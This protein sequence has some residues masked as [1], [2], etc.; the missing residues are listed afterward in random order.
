MV[1]R[2]LLSRAAVLLASVSSVLAALPPIQVR[3]SNFVD[4]STGQ[5]FAVLGVDYQPGGQGAYG[6]GKGDP[7]SDP[8]ACLRDAVVM[9]RLGV[10]TIRIYNIDSSL[11][12]DQCMSIFDMAGIYVVLDVNSPLSGESIDRSNPK[13]TYSADYLS[14]IFAVV[15]AFKDYP[16]LLAF[17]AGNEVI[18]DLPTAADNPPVMRAVQRD[19][20]NYI[21]RHAPRTIPVG[22]S[23]ADVREILQDTWEYLQCNNNDNSSADFFGLNSYSWCGSTATFDT[24]GYDD[25][26]KMFA[27]TAIPIFFSEYGCNEVMPRV[28]NEVQALYG[29]NMTTLSGGLIYE[30][31]SEGN[32]YGL[33]TINSNGSLNLGV[34]FVNLV[35]QYNKVDIGLLE[36][37]N[38]TSENQKAPACDAKLIQEKGFSTDFDI[39]GPPSGGQQL[40]NRGIQNPPKGSL[41]SVTATAVKQPVFNTNGAAIQNLVLKQSN[42]SNTPSGVSFDDPNSGSGSGSAAA[43]P[44]PSG[45]ASA[46]AVGT[47]SILAAIFGVAAIL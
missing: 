7:L 21:A 42:G 47:G 25:I 28:F 13:G 27:S 26:V 24:S 22:Y 30:Y 1:G 45:G 3:G 4:S 14:H 2:S 29:P 32:N 44:S 41:V 23:A 15:E 6:T 19:L 8:D 17:F 38:S 34:D 35:G 20:K 10:N 33:V 39:P 18:N 11:N 31:S 5:R 36:S 9:Q 37:A 46:V 43:S 12:H 40:I 16:N